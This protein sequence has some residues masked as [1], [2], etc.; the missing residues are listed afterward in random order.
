MRELTR[1]RPAGSRVLLG[2][3]PIYAPVAVYYARRT[4]GAEVLIVPPAMPGAEFFYGTEPQSPG[5]MKMIR[6]YPATG[7][8]LTT[9]GR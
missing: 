6:S 2:V 5:R 3:E 8:V 4:S 7:T 9:L 1:Q